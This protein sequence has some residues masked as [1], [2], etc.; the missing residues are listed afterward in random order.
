[1]SHGTHT[2][3]AFEEAVEAGLL[4]TGRYEKRPPSMYLSPTSSPAGSCH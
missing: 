3:T 1:M 4:G 2:E